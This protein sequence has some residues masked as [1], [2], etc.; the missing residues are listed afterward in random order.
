MKFTKIAFLLVFVLTTTLAMAQN[1][2]KAQIAKDLGITEEQVTT[3]DAIN[4]KYAEEGKTLKANTS[5]SKKEKAAK[6]KE[7]K[8]KREQEM[9]ALLGQEKYNE[10]QAYL[11]EKR[12]AQQ[13]ARATAISELGLTTE[14]DQQLKAINQKYAKEGKTIKEDA[15]LTP[16]QKKAKGKE[17]NDKRLVEIKAILSAE[18]YEKFVAM[19]QK[20]RPQPK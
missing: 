19:E 7:L 20:N 15:A 2:N 16:E 6:A 13:E 12:T 4:K 18:Q 11:A 1:K 14:Q 3:F 5:I 10:L 17:L 8:T 9:V